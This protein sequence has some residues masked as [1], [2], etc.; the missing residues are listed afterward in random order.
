[1]SNVI[2]IADVKPSRV[3][4]NLL[5]L[6]DIL[7][8]NALIITRKLLDIADG[9]PDIRLKTRGLLKI[10]LILVG[11]LIRKGNVFVHYNN[12]HIFFQYRVNMLLY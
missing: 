2:N 6:R 1:M 9:T 8:A 3:V 10:S 5:P 7:N 12:Q 4:G 11:F